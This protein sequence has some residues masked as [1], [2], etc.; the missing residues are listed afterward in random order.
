MR[1]PHSPTADWLEAI[2]G[3]RGYEGADFGEE[4]TDRFERDGAVYVVTVKKER[5]DDG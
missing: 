2:A 1:N 5:A 3:Q 4:G